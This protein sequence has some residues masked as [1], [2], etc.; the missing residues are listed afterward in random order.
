MVTAKGEVI[1]AVA[2]PARL[3]GREHD[4]AVAFTEERLIF[5]RIG[6]ASPDTTKDELRHAGIFLPGSSSAV[7]VSRFYE[8]TP[9]QVLD[10]DNDNFSL[11]NSEVEGVRLAYEAEG[12]GRYVITIRAEEGEVVFTLPYDRYYRDLLFRQFEGRVTW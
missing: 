2:S 5:A 3:P 7:N 11:D 1:G 4:Y 9:A 12:G 8:M 6:K 10:E